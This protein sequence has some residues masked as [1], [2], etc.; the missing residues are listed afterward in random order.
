MIE[1]VFLSSDLGS[2]GSGHRAQGEFYRASG[3]RGSGSFLLRCSFLRSP[4]FSIFGLFPCGFR[5]KLRTGARGFWAERDYL[6]Q[7]MQEFLH[8]KA[9]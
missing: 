2:L 9:R 4:F 6:G 1:V 7:N 5:L 8:T 3:L